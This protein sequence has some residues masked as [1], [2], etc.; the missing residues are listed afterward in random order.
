MLPIPRITRTDLLA[1]L[2]LIVSVAFPR[3]TWAEAEN[4]WTFIEAWRTFRYDLDSSIP[5][6][7]GE[8]LLIE[9][10][11]PRE[12]WLVRDGLRL[13]SNPLVIARL[14][15]RAASV[16]DRTAIAALRH[17]L[18]GVSDDNARRV[19]E[20]ALLRLGDEE[21][22]QRLV[23]R[24]RKGSSPERWEAAATLASAGKK[25]IPAL[26]TA[27]ADEDDL[28]KIA[29]ASA[30]ASLGEKRAKK[31][32]GKLLSSPNRYLRLEAAHALALA[33]DPRSLPVLQ[34][35]LDL[36]GGERTRLARSIG[37]VGKAQDRERLLQ[38]YRSLARGRSKELRS[39]LLHAIGEITLR[40]ELRELAPRITSEEGA[41]LHEGLRHVWLEELGRAV[42]A[43]AKSR[44]TMANAVRENSERAL[45]KETPV[46]QQRRQA[47]AKLL[48]ALLTTGE[49][50]SAPVPSLPSDSIAALRRAISS[51]SAS[52]RARMERFGAA[53]ALL[54]R[55]GKQLGHERLAEP[56]EVRAVGLGAHRSVDGNL[57]TS[58]VAGEMAGPL[59][60]ELV[61]PGRVKR[62]HLIGGCIDSRS[63]YSEHA[64]ARTIKLSLDGRR[65]VEEQ[66]DDDSPYFQQVE[67]PSGD[68]AQISLEI[69]DVYAGRRRDAPACI[70]EIRLER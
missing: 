39:Q 9:R 42:A 20:R 17:A 57:M 54:E 22:R 51:K 14:A 25:A 7:H 48:L 16:G 15:R 36:P 21:L 53:L 33:D 45:L 19:V 67:L 44:E 34:E 28:T 27:M 58:W 32:L 46:A 69:V 56:P 23:Q 30:L 38:V 8:V 18:K 49:L 13:S 3:V 37:R 12:R 6:E 29:A 4:A 64:R 41:D 65:V 40:M 11:E 62:L 60:L 24:L 50:P 1:L 26:R 70:S 52:A 2:L 47:R 10:L 43:G 68:I 63:S 35:R 31:L 5:G 59:R 66:L 55:T 61:H